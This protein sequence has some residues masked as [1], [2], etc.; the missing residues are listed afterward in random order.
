MIV[1]KCAAN[2]SPVGD[3]GDIMKIAEIRDSFLCFRFCFFGGSGDSS[4]RSS[5]Q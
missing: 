5:A 2:P 1:Y 3:I 4:Q